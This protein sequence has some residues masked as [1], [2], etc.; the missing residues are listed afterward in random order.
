[1]AGW[2]DGWKVGWLV[3][4]MVGWMV[5]RFDG[6]TGGME[7]HFRHEVSLTDYFVRPA[8]RFIVRP[9][10]QAS[11]MIITSMRAPLPSLSTCL[12]LPFTI[13]P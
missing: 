9:S 3:G 6:R 4:W 10:Y 7:N 1:M 12:S 13:S 5:G 2:L 8:F 11:V